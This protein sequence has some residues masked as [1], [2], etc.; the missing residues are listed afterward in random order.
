MITL[1]FESLTDKALR[2]ERKKIYE[3][4]CLRVEKP[5]PIF[6]TFNYQIITMIFKYPNFPT[7]IKYLIFSYISL[8]ITSSFITSII[9]L[10][11]LYIPPCVYTLGSLKCLR[12]HFHQIIIYF[13]PPVFILLL[14]L[15]RTTFYHPQYFIHH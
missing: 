5:F 6:P 13:T 3:K 2:F 1:K 4:S 12:N 8:H 14:H 11:Y 15:M 9:L 10:F 7:F